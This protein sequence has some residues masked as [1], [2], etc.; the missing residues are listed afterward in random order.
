MPVSQLKIQPVKLTVSY[1]S[2]TVGTA[3]RTIER[4]TRLCA[5]AMTVKEVGAMT[6]HFATSLLH[7]NYQALGGDLDSSSGV[8]LGCIASKPRALGVTSRPVTR[9]GLAP[10]PGSM[11]DLCALNESKAPT[12]RKYGSSSK[13]ALKLAYQLELAKYLGCHSAWPFTLW[14]LEG[15]S[16]FTLT[17]RRPSGGTTLTEVI[18]WTVKLPDN[19]F[20]NACSFAEMPFWA[21][22]KLDYSEAAQT[23]GEV[24]LNINARENYGLRLQHVFAQGYDDDGTPGFDETYADAI[25]CKFKYENAEFFDAIA[26]SRVAI[27]SLFPGFISD[28]E[29]SRNLDVLIN[30]KSNLIFDLDKAATTNPIDLYLTAYGTCVEASKEFKQA[31]R[32]TLVTL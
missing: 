26:Q 16:P 4:D 6:D 31:Q 1:S 5:F 18:L 12:L 28:L 25:S 2:A 9:A 24:A 32:P 14:P 15:G 11:N 29:Q 23:P 3:T 7:N 8:P 10:W 13:E 19:L 17:L 27:T 20:K 30:P 21:N 22:K